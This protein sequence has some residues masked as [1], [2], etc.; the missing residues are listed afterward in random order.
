MARLYKHKRRGWQVRYMLY[1]PNGTQEPRYRYRQTR[2]QASDLCADADEFERLA[3]RGELG[4]ERAVYFV[5]RQLLSE[6]E[7]SALIGAPARIPTM[8]DLAQVLLA[9]SQDEC[10]PAVHV[11][12]KGRIATVLRHFGQDLPAD[13]VTREMVESYRS[14]RLTDKCRRK[15]DV[16][17]SPATVNKELTKVA[18]ILDIAVDQHIITENPA[19]HLQALKDKRG[20]VP[21]SLTAGEITSLLEACAK[22]PEL[23]G[24]VAC[25]VMTTYLYTGMRRSE[26]VYLQCEDVDLSRRSITIQAAIDPEGFNTKSRKARVIGLAE[27]LLPVIAPFVQKGGI[28]VFGGDTIIEHPNSITRAFRVLA[29][30]AKLSPSITLHSL[31]H[32]YITHLLEAGVPIRRVQELAGHAS[33]STTLRYAHV[34]PTT[35]IA[36]DL[37]NFE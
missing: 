7:A 23:L 15:P 19:R 37:L 36:E 35:A 22:H 12:N 5:R 25:E 16:T 27:K 34:L 31:R 11:T 28:Y 6:Q 18:Q 9:R 32:T 3:M 21:R 30:E 4:R 13:A 29:D 14:K 20:R 17:V 10:R 26:L 8:D 33:M 1:L 24:G 2:E